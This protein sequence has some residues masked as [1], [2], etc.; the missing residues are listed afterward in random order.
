MKNKWIAVILGSM[1]GVVVLVLVMGFS[2]MFTYVYPAGQLSEW[3][4]YRDNITVT[5]NNTALLDN[6]THYISSSCNSYSGAGIKPI[7]SDAINMRGFTRLHLMLVTTGGT[8][9][10][11]CK[12]VGF[13][14]TN[15]SPGLPI[16]NVTFTSTGDNATATTVIFKASL[17]ATECAPNQYV[18]PLL[19]DNGTATRINMW[20]RRD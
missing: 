20:Y 7:P 19:V 10:M 15:V 9:D 8:T 3:T 16:D 12:V 17:G 14:G 13:D 18:V 2:P 4:L 11:K 5:D 6:V 1:M